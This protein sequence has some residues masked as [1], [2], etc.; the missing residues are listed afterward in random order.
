MVHRVAMAL[1][2]SVILPFSMLPALLYDIVDFPLLNLKQTFLRALGALIINAL[3]VRRLGQVEHVIVAI[4]HQRTN[5]ETPSDCFLGVQ[6][7]GEIHSIT[8]DDS[9]VEELFKLGSILT[10]AAELPAVLSVQ[11][12]CIEIGGNTTSCTR[13]SMVKQ[14][15]VLALIA[16]LYTDAPHRP[17]C[18]RRNLRHAL[19]D[20]ISSWTSLEVI[21]KVFLGCQRLNQSNSNSTGEVHLRSQTGEVVHLLLQPGAK[22]ASGFHWHLKINDRTAASLVIVPTSSP[23]TADSVAGI[24][25]TLGKNISLIHD[26]PKSCDSLL[27]KAFSIPVCQIQHVAAGSEV[28]NIIPIN[29]GGC[30]LLLDALD[31]SYEMAESLL[32]LPMS[33]IIRASILQND[34]SH[35][36]LNQLPAYG[37]VILS[38]NEAW[39][40]F[41]VLNICNHHTVFIDKMLSWLLVTLTVNFVWVAQTLPRDPTLSLPVFFNFLLCVT[42]SLS[43]GVTNLFFQFKRIT[44]LFQHTPLPVRPLV[45]SARS[46]ESLGRALAW[47]SDVSLQ[48]LVTNS[49]NREKVPVDVNLASTRSGSLGC[50]EMTDL[51]G[52]V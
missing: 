40:I 39:D 38:R 33:K 6:L 28:A 47:P 48:E 17:L 24:Q 35:Y 11:N 2:L 15:T 10:A 44:R 23:E 3:D 22:D 41:R 32:E 31:E 20:R 26:L 42:N 27:A 29:S 19:L 7:N 4:S 25:L 1:R 52:I 5:I 46:P 8:V 45:D 12:A 37:N 50:T 9:S 18:G 51:I 36:R 34:V 13:R 16:A 14:S 43:F 49:A 21:E 30:I